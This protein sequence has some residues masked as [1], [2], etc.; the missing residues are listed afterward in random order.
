MLRII[1][2]K[3]AQNLSIPSS[4]QQVLQPYT[5]MIQWGKKEWDKRQKEIANQKANKANQDLLD[6]Y[7]L[8]RDPKNGTCISCGKYNAIDERGYKFCPTP[9]CNKRY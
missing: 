7:E 2:P 1:N 8:S 6:R 5:N 3:L 4:D 9:T